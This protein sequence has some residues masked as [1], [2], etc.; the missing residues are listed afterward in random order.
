MQ[1]PSLITG[2]T[3]P[4]DWGPQQRNGTST[5]QKGPTF[6]TA[7]TLAFCT[8]ILGPSVPRRQIISGNDQLPLFS[9]LIGFCHKENLMSLPKRFIKALGWSHHCT[10]ELLLK[11]LNQSV[12][13][14]WVFRKLK[15]SQQKASPW[16]KMS[17]NKQ[18]GFPPAPTHQSNPVS[19]NIVGFPYV[20]DLH[21]SALLL[22]WKPKEALTCGMVFWAVRLNHA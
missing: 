20:S 16:D 11:K 21:Q 10:D 18:S 8:C 1:P 15:G 14:N 4:T 22:D 12:Q 6:C 5:P 13:I 7:P 17:R 2:I 19:C 9:P 3:Q